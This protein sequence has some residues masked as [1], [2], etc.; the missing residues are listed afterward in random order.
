MEKQQ[1]EQCHRWYDPRYHGISFSGLLNKRVCGYCSNAA[2][3]T[4]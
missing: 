2:A 1:C 3:N 4:T